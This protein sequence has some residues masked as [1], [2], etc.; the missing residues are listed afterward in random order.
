[1]IKKILKFSPLLLILPIF[2]FPLASVEAQ[3]FL[4]C[5][6]VDCSACNLVDTAN[7]VIKWLFGIIFMI[8]AVMMMIAGFKLVTSGGNTSALEDAKSKFTN[9]IVGLIIVMAA[10]LLV[11]TIMR[12]LLK[13]GTGEIE[14]YGP[15]A[16][17][18]CQTQTQPVEFG[19]LAQAND[20]KPDDSITASCTDDAA[21]MAKYSGSPM[22]AEAPG[23]RDMINCYLA[24][25]DINSIVDH[26]QLYTFDRTNP[27]C[28]LTNGFPVCGSCSHS[29][30]SMHYGRGSGQGAK[31][32]DFN[33]SGAS[34]HTLN[35][36]L[37]ARQ[38]ICG[39]KIL[40]ENSHTHI[41]L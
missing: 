24:D 39:G 17:V 33:A 29:R 27:K 21:L 4:T 9:A 18:Q 3:G 10:W 25:S 31:A 15:W 36:K 6:G 13:G 8:F 12:G 35:A 7:I 5:D 1:M 2:L 30:N 16:D 14:N 11:D 20:V 19:E 26:N 38:S 23:L 34:E 32:V 22:G 41:S 37:K 40:F 28:S